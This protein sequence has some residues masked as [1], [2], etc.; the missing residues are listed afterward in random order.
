MSDLQDIIATS[1]V[2]AFNSGIH[3]E[4]KRILKML[5]EEIVK[6]EEAASTLDETGILI[7]LKRAELHVKELKWT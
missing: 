4:R 5:N 7:G 3:H 1:T 6:Q 2:R